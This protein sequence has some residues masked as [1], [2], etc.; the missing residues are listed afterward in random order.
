MCNLSSEHGEHPRP[1]A[2]VRFSKLSLLQ[3]ND[4]VSEQT[5]WILYRG[6]RLHAVK[7][8]PP[9]PASLYSLTKQKISFT[10]AASGLECRQVYLERS[11]FIE[12]ICAKGKKTPGFALIWEIFKIFEV[13]CLCTML[14]FYAEIARPLS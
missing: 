1:P 14:L 9:A 3:S 7:F 11:I 4:S 2:G 8:N 13:C 12:F 6:E 10:L 5:V